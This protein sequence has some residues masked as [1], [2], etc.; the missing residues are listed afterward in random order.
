[1]TVSKEEYI[2]SLEK[3]LIECQQQSVKDFNEIEQ[4][5]AALSDIFALIEEGKLVRKVSRDECV[6]FV[7][8]LR[9]SQEALQTEDSNQ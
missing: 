6:A 7:Q 2:A 9:K 4:L 3:Q 5:Q 8:R 1:M